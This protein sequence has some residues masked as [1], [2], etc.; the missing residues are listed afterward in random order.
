MSL[1]SIHNENE[2]NLCMTAASGMDQKVYG[3][4]Y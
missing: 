4:S 1:Y 3:V 2:P